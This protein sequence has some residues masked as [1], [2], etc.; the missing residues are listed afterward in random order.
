MRLLA[1]ELHTKLTQRI[2]TGPKP[3]QV[4]AL[5]PH[6]LRYLAPTG[7]LQMQIEDDTG[8][9]LQVSE[10]I[11]IAS[12]PAGNYFHGYVRFLINCALRANT[13]YRVSLL[14]LSG[15]S[16]SESAWVGWCN[17]Y[18]LRKVQAN[19]SPNIGWSAALD[20]ELW[21]TRNAIRRVG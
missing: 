17:D 16:F 1:H 7:S 2:T 8:S 5:R 4:T 15:Y 10:T 6:L 20:L 14:A 21:E 9:I 13:T 18:D 3:I 11:A 12:L 19:Y